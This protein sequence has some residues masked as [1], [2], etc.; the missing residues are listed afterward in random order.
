MSFTVSSK[1]QATAPNAHTLEQQAIRAGQKP[2]ARERALKAAHASAPAPE[3]P[4]PSPEP[5]STTE[6]AQALHTGIEVPKPTETPVENGQ[7][8]ST[9]APKSVEATP[10]APKAPETPKE[11]LSSQYAQ[12]ARKERAL[13]AKA[14]ELKQREDAL[15][16]KTEAS[17][18]SFD[19]T[20][21]IPIEDFQKN[22]WKYMQES[23]VS[24][25]QITKA[26]LEAPSPE[27]AAQQQ[28]F[29]QM[30]A[31]ITELEGKVNGTQKSWEDNQKTQYQQALSQIKSEVTSLVNQNPEF[32]TITATGS[33]DDVVE[34]I[35]KTFQEDGVLLSVEDATK[36]VEDYLVEEAYKLSQLPKIQKRFKPAPATVEAAPP[37][38]GAPDPKQSQPSKTLTNAISGSRELTRRERAM[39]AAIHGPNWRDK[40]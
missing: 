30:Q 16:P 29:D 7:S 35:E 12:L 10:E 31:K 11:P 26:A 22:P 17:Q 14:L 21:H 25:D 37:K 27:Q 9:E 13:R 24:Y 3:A 36:Q 28:L 32:E 39:A 8:Q 15:K 1:G 2:S 40:I 6:V 5:L 20:K 33:I 4:K 34:L 19:P 18:P 23:K 38:T